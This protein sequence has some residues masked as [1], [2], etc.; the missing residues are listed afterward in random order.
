MAPDCVAG[1]CARASYAES[2]RPVP[3]GVSFFAV[4]SRRDGIVDW[5]ACLDPLATPV[6]VR[7]S[8]LGLVVEP[9]AIRA[10]VDAVSAGVAPV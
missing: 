6:E 2:R 1:E 5:R 4:Y 8:H 9:G 7:S 10:V 3:A